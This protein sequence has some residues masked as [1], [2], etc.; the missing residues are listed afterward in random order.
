MKKEAEERKLHK[1]AKVHDFL[2]MWQGRQNL[3]ATQKESC[4]HNKQMTSEG[5]ISDREEIVK[6]SWTLF[7]HDGAAAFQLS[8]RSLLPLAL[9][10]KDLPGGPT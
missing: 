5:Y 1:M 6:A 7:H 3:R 8:E 10:V 9:S 2:E 4:A